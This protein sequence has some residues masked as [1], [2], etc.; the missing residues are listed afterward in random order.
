MGEACVSYGED[1]V[2]IQRFS[3][4][5]ER[6]GKFGKLSRREDNIKVDL[7]EIEWDRRLDGFDSW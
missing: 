4:E 3:R 7:Q 6:K 2:C 1:K 5:S